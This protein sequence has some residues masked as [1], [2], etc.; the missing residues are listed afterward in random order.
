[1]SARPEA[2]PPRGP[3]ADVWRIPLDGG[4]RTVRRAVR[5]LDARERQRADRFRDALAADRFVLAH[6]AARS[7]LGRYL[8]VSGEAVHWSVGPH[9]KP[10]FTGPWGEWQWS[11]SR[12]DGLALLAVCAA[13]PVGVDLE[14]VGEQTRALALARRFLPAR[15]AADVGRL[16]VP[17]SSGPATDGAAAR[18]AYHR[19]LSRKEACIKASGGRLLDGL[20]LDVL[21]PGPVLGD[22][23]FA[24]HRWFLRDLPAPPG[25]VAALAT[26]GG[27][28]P[29][30][31]LFDWEWRTG[32][33]GIPAGPD[34]L[35]GREGAGSPDEARPCRPRAGAAPGG[36]GR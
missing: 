22:G 9:G 19:L 30:L 15:E 18:L 23:A 2:A 24:G 3:E 10:Y 5:L 11:L 26:L 1:M 25:F 14:R 34:H 35:R 29:G 36:W 27:A 4:G 8:G 7:I 12:A 33:S 28:E 13:V 17:P 32:P 21:A 31:R 20:R 6:A 16:L